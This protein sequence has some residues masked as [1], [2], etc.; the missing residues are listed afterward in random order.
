MLYQI[1]DIIA[2]NW[3]ITGYMILFFI[4]KEYFNKKKGSENTDLITQMYFN[5]QWDKLQ[6]R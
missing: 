3:S 5:K 4:I 1:I 6:V 2:N